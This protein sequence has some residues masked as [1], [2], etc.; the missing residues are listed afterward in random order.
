MSELEPIWDKQLFE[1]I[2]LSPST[3]IMASSPPSPRL[4]K[5]VI[6]P[7]MKL[8]FTRLAKPLLPYPKFANSPCPFRPNHLPQL[9]ILNDHVLAAIITSEPQPP[10][11]LGVDV[12]TWGD[13]KRTLLS[14]AERGLKFFESRVTERVQDLAP[15]PF[16]DRE[17]IKVNTRKPL[18][19]ATDGRQ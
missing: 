11:D 15:G 7:L 4:V 13:E 10:D 9:P 3:S 12:Q 8:T 14:L 5:P 1:L 19:Y 2:Y 17:G 16:K 18:L 6:P